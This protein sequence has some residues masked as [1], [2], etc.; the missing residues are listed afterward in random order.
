MK[1]TEIF[2][3]QFDIEWSYFDNNEIS[4]AKVEKLNLQIKFIKLRDDMISISFSINNKMSTTH[5]NKDQFI[6]FSA[7]YQ[8][9]NE[10]LSKNNYIDS[11]VFEC[12]DA[13]KADLY[14]LFI[15][16]Y[17]SK[18]GF[19]LVKDTTEQWSNNREFKL[20]RTSKL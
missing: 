11:V 2:D 20:W 17:A 13:K 12:S 7:V 10:Y 6:I 1:L 19:K 4:I 16:K 9:I 18:F 5:K 14:K 15:D 3:K 8:A